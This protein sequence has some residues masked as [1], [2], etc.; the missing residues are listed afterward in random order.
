MSKAKQRE[1]ANIAKVI[2]GGIVAI[3]SSIFGVK[4]IKNKKKKKDK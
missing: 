3:G 1:I 2:V 4:K